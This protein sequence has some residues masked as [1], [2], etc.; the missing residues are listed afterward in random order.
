MPDSA[1][2]WSTDYWCEVADHAQSGT[3]TFYTRLIPP[4]DHVQLDLY[5]RY[6]LLWL[7]DRYA[8]Q[9]YAY[10]PGADQEG[11]LSLLPAHVDPPIYWRS[12]LPLDQMFYFIQRGETLIPLR[13]AITRC[14][15]CS[16]P[17]L[18]HASSGHCLYE[19]TSFYTSYRASRHSYDRRTRTFR[20]ED[21]ELYV[22]G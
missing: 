4:G 19:P 7:R 13:T 1:F 16:H 18:E 9:P 17:A 2:E 8:E 21:R 14:E 15:N 10:A 3:L 20:E 6:S 22:P 5:N 12:A 11:A